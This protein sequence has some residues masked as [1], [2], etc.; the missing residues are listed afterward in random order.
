MVWI[1]SVSLSKLYI[2]FITKQQQ[3]SRKQKFVVQ[4]GHTRFY[5]DPENNFVFSSKTV[6]SVSSL[7]RTVYVDGKLR[8]AH[9]LISLYN[10][11]VAIRV[12]E[13]GWAV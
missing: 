2:Y 1:I 9:G 7:P 5:I 13:P 12:L 3:K 10:V 11:L 4:V 6:N 8:L